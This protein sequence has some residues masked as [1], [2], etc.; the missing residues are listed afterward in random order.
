MNLNCIDDNLNCNECDG[1]IIV[2]CQYCNGSGEGHSEYQKCHACHGR[3][4]Y[5]TNCEYNC[6]Y[7]ET[8]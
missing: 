4:E 3:G 8:I 7:K 5:I 2:D 1:K 6:E